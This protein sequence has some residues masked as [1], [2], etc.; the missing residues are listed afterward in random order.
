MPT[1]SEVLDDEGSSTLPLRG[2]D[3]FGARVSVGTGTN[4]VLSGALVALVSDYPGFTPLPDPKRGG[5]P[6]PARV[7][8]DLVAGF[9]EAVYLGQPAAVAKAIRTLRRAHPR[10]AR[11][12]ERLL[13][14]RPG[15]QQLSR[16]VQV[17]LTGEVPAAEE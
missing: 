12:L 9:L 15:L 2:A 13:L 14:D 4:T 11:W 10:Q 1:I 16:A 5:V 17:E 3:G 6:V 7:T 8:E